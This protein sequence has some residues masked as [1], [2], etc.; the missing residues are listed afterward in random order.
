MDS[1]SATQLFSR[2][3]GG[4]IE[5][6]GGAER[7]GEFKLLR[8]NVDRGHLRAKG[9]SELHSKVS[10]ATYAE[11]SQALTGHNPGTLQGA[12]NCES[13][14]KNGGGFEPRKTIWNFQRVSCRRL[15]KFAVPTSN[16]DTGVLL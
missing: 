15:D 8:R 11:N 6:V 10:Q 2:I 14:T 1:T 4:S 5:R 7:S 12:I 3:S 16:G 9:P 13:S